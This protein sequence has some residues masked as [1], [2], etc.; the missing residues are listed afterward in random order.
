MTSSAADIRVGDL[1]GKS[2]QN[3][4]E[5]VSSVLALTRRGQSLLSNLDD[6]ELRKYDDL[7]TVMEGQMTHGA[8]MPAIRDKVV[9]QLGGQKT[10]NQIYSGL[11]WRYNLRF[12][13]ERIIRKLKRMAKL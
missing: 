11:I 8:R 7:S 1:W 9:E 2:Y 6:I 4:T 3:N 13:P 10:L 5:G 12:L